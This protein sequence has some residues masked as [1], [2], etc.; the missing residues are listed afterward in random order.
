MLQMH[1]EGTRFVGLISYVNSDSGGRTHHEEDAEAGL[2]IEDHD[3]GAA[4][5]VK[6]QKVAWNTKVNTRATQ[7]RQGN[8][9]RESHHDSKRT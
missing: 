9:A 4:L 1:H 7:V 8:L 6:I 3:H 2:E 5:K